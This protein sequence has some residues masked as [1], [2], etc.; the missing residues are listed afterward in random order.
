MIIMD[1]MEQMMLRMTELQPKIPSWAKAEN[2]EI[3]T[4]QKDLWKYMKAADV[5]VYR[6]LCLGILGRAVN[7]PGA[8]ARNMIVALY[9]VTQKFYGFN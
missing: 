5:H 4:P 2:M 9:R 6:K 8:G 3:C 7:L 1:H